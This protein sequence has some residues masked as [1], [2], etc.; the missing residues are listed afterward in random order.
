MRWRS[1]RL[2]FRPFIH[3]SP[4]RIDATLLLAGRKFDIMRLLLF[5]NNWGGWQLARWLRQEREDVVGVV[6]QPDTDQRFAPQILENLGLPPDRVWRAPQLR[7]SETIARMRELRPDVGI[8][9]FFGYILKPDVLSL[10][11]YGCIN[12]HPASLPFNRGWHTNVWPIIDGSPAGVTV[13]YMDEGVDTG[14]IIAQRTIAVQPTDTGGSLH[15]KLTRSMVALF[16]QAWPLIKAGEHVRTPQNPASGSS[17]RKAD[18]SAIDEVDLARKY[19]A[20]DLLDLLRARTYSPFPAAYFMTES[21]K[22]YLRVQL[23]SE[24]DLQ[25]R[26]ISG[27][28]RHSQPI[29][30]D[31]GYYARDL[32]RL[33]T[34]GDDAPAYFVDLDGA[35]RIFVRGQLVSPEDVN[36]NAVPAWI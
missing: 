7:D 19:R 13:H 4:E 5:L 26:G 2:R 8:S 20:R 3:I 10:P 14:D 22:T 9:A 11:S 16:E 6:V 28:P 21:R 27:V 35:C 17:H 12:L 29:D 32:L 25:A 34:T 30:L 23:E 24:G 31:R 1:V 33:L 18:L 36:P 15:Q